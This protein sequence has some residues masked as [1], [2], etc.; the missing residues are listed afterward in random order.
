ML[1]PK[2]QTSSRF[3]EK[4]MKQIWL[5]GF[6]SI[7]LLL[8]GCNN[9][10]SNNPSDLSDELET[11]ASKTIMR[12][13][14]SEQKGPSKSNIYV[15]EIQDN[16]VGHI[17]LFDSSGSKLVNLDV[18][19]GTVD[20]EQI[21]FEFDVLD[22][23][24]SE[25]SSL[26]A[27]LLELQDSNS[28]A[29]EFSTG[30]FALLWQE[31]SLELSN[32]E[33]KL[34]SVCKDPNAKLSIFIDKSVTPSVPTIEGLEEGDD[35]RPVGAF[36]TADGSQSELVYNELIVA[37]YSQA[38]LD[39]LLKRSNG[40]VLDSFSK[41]S[42]SA[43]DDPDE[44]LIRVNPNRAN[45]KNIEA[46]LLA[47]EPYQTGEI[48]VSDKDTLRLLAMFLQETLTHSTE[49]SLNWL[50]KAHDISSGT[51]EEGT[52]IF[53]GRIKI[54][55]A[56]DLSYIKYDSNQ[57]TGVDIAWQLLEQYG[58]LGNKVRI[59]IV[60]GGFYPN[61]DFPLTRKIRKAAWE[62]K[63]PGSFGWHGTQVTLAAMGQLDNG[64][65]TA[66]PAGP[67]GELIAVGVRE[68]LWKNLRRVR[69][70]VEEE[71]PHIVNMSYS[72]DINSFK[73]STEKKA[74]RHYKAMRNA[75]ALLFA[76][77]GNDGINVDAEKC[78]IF[79]T[80]RESKLILPCESPHVICVGGMGHKSIFEADD[81]NYGRKK[82]DRSVEIYGP[83]TMLG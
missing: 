30:K 45:P 68:G 48:R 70:M 15:K 81:S 60:D 52:R 18:K 65:G 82:N 72:T 26:I 37:V 27:K 47:L 9:S 78:T 73:G 25:E 44:Y 61:L 74:N 46:D 35:P 56:F 5:L 19:N 1:Q 39:A 58:K 8:S 76:A 6:L 49:V 3:K 41:D 40:V 55:D 17:L 4:F 12:L 31:Q 21:I 11:Q 10:S 42:F 29:T 59:M 63:G 71:R 13:V 14:P 50:V 43:P 32:I 20:C 64:Y 24:T 75:G 62:K 7:V 38:E 36:I 28:N 54:V 66:G 57:S 22:P 79:N 51:S 77:A 33:Y 80:C 83:F 16:L 69:A 23:S 67:V 53:D 34:P 2:K